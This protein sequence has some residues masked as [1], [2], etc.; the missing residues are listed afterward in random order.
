MLKQQAPLSNGYYFIRNVGSGK[1]LDVSNG[2]TDWF[3]HVVHYNFQGTMNQLWEVEDGIT[4]Y[5]RIRSGLHEHLYM[6]IL[7]G[8]TDSGTQVQV[9][10]N[11]GPNLESEN[12]LIVSNGDGTF[13]IHPK[14]STDVAVSASAGINVML[15][16]YN[17][18][19]DNMRWYFEKAANVNWNYSDYSNGSYVPLSGDF[20]VSTYTEESQQLATCASFT[21]DTNNVNE[22]LKYNIGEGAHSDAQGYDCFLTIDVT[23]VRHSTSS[24]DDLSATFVFTNL[25]NPKIDIEDDDL[26]G[27]RNEESEVCVLGEVESNVGYHVTTIWDDHR[28]FSGSQGRIQCQFAMS[29]HGVLDYNN[30]ITSSSVQAIHQLGNTQNQP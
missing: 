26:F 29:K 8:W 7:N 18:N 22:I 5:K 4:G 12:F 14:N 13:R 19:N 16:T 11:Y 9:F 20:C 21:L 3:T 24:V 6:D 10:G 2:C 28:D 1:Y 17:P 27:S 30:V 15:A 23:N 25:P